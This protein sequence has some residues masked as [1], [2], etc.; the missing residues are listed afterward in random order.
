MKYESLAAEDTSL[1]SCSLSDAS[2]GG[3]LKLKMEIKKIKSKFTQFYAWK[4]L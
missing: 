1:S 4:L 3:I 2:F